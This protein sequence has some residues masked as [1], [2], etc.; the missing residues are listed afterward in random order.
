MTKSNTDDNKK[1]KM[2]HNKKSQKETLV[3][4]SLSNKKSQK[5]IIEKNS[6]PNKKKK[7][8]LSDNLSTANNNQYILEPVE[9][10]RCIDINIL[11]HH[12][13]KDIDSNKEYFDDLGITY[14]ISN[15]LKAEWMVH[16]SI[17]NSKLVGSGNN[18]VDIM[19]NNICIDVSVLTLNNTSYTN[20]K[21]IMQNFSTGN[22]LDSLF[23]DSKGDE[24]T[25]IFRKKLQEKYLANNNKEIYYI[26]FVCHKKNTYLVS[27]KF[28]PKNIANMEFASFSES[29]KTIWIDNFINADFGTVKLY[30]SKKRLE[31]RLSKNIINSACSVKI[32]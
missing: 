18:C 6:L 27:L 25:K 22:N 4:N 8:L 5:E 28:N 30:K 24:A 1:L 19:T 26:I 31:L 23:N 9:I 14:K 11:Q 12:V 10:P 13:K 15:P 32:F 21:S 3:K 16:K 2:I 20:E 17:A 29:N 7:T